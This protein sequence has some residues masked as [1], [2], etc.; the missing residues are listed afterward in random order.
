[1]AQFAANC[2]LCCVHCLE[3]FVRFFNKH[4][5]VEI[6]MRSTC[7][8]VSAVNGMRVV[9][10]NFLRFG[11]LHGLGEIVMNLGVLFICMTGTYIG[12]LLIIYTSPAKREFHGTAGSLFVAYFVILG[13]LCNNVGSLLS[14]C[15]YMGNFC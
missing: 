3:R 7:Y 8:C 12:Y 2:L 1:M 15:S 14:I 10:T 5:Y 4:A 6:A 11:I 13:C 9:T